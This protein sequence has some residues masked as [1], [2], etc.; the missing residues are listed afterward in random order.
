MSQPL[1][2]PPSSPARPDRPAP[3]AEEAAPGPCA[4]PPC[5]D[6]P[7]TAGPP[8]AEA[9][10]CLFEHA[11]CRVSG[12]PVRA[13]EE[14]RG[15]AAATELDRVA[16]LTAV[17]E[18][19]AGPLADGLY[20]AIG[21][22]GDKPLR[23]RLL[24]L[25][26]DV[27]NRRRPRPGDVEAAHASLGGA[28]AGRLEAYAAAASARE[29]AEARLPD[30][31]RSDL[32]HARRTLRRWAA[33]AD[34]AKGLLLSSR[35]LSAEMERYLAS[36]VAELGAKERQIERGLLRY[37]TRMAM[38]TTP[39][40]TFTALTAGR[41]AGGEES[42]SAGAEPLTFTADPRRKRSLV[43]LN[44][45]LFTVVVDDLLADRD[46]R[47]A[48]PVE[49]N[50]TLHPEDPE[51]TGSRE[52]A[53]SGA[54]RW[55]FLVS[56]D[57]L[58]VFQ[59]LAHGPV[60]DLYRQLLADGPRPLAEIEELL[61]GDSRLEAGRAEVEAFSDRLLEIGL[62][63]TRTGV[64]VQEADW[65]RPL[66]RA[67]AAVE[68]EAAARARDCL[69]RLRELCD[70]Y[71]AAAVDERRELLGTTV[72]TFRDA[73]D[74]DRRHRGLNPPFYEDAGTAA[75]LPIP[76]ARLAAAVGDLAAYVR[77]TR[78][79]AWPRRE[80]V[81]MRHFHDRHHAGR[82][83][84]LLRFYEDYHREHMKGF[85]EGRNQAVQ[86][87]AARDTLAADGEG[88]GEA[89]EAGAEPPP[90][91]DYQNPFGL[92]SVEAMKRANE[93]LIRRQRRLWRA[94]PD[95]AVLTLT[96]EDLEAATAGLP[97][98]S[99]A[100]LSTSVFCQLLPGCG[101]GGATALLMRSLLAGCG[102]Y[103]SRFLEV[104]PP[105]VR[106]DLRARN[107]SR[108]DVLLA[109]IGADGDFNANLH[110]SL[111]PWEIAYP[112]G[113]GGAAE[114][115]LR[116]PDLVVE[117]SPSEAGSLVLRHAPSG[118]RVVPL[119]LG[120]QNPMMR[121][122]LFRL[123]SFLGPPTNYYLPLPETPWEP[124]AEPDPEDRPR[125]LYR[126]RIAFGGGLFLGRRRWTVT[127]RSFPARHGAESASDHFARVD[128]WRRTHGLPR[129]VFLRIQRFTR[130]G[131]RRR[132]HLN[133]PQ[134]VD[135]ANP[136]LVDRFRRSADGLESFAMHL[137]ER[138]P[139]RDQLPAFG[140]ERFATEL[141]LQLDTRGEVGDV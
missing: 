64:P 70:D 60:V 126:P 83:V 39:F 21:G 82:P 67:L 108:Q 8:R 91:L 6:D 133:K 71:A 38:K 140:D 75:E 122:P 98:V 139:H 137:T 32:E 66:R 40:G 20:D 16:E 52:G 2:T 49:L 7:V 76:R 101:S 46:V 58:E 30:L 85:L 104:M 106:S 120:F 77:L 18:G 50:P 88:P 3:A 43:R 9:G 28:D 31:H 103:F 47:R 107:G 34:F 97:P 11:V 138:L 125:V 95:A 48:L 26:R 105:R 44:K 112:T 109:E 14:M 29:R 128:R 10:L 45:R 37:L 79:L 136:L 23:R 129:E 33:D 73:Y 17:M 41:L 89:D 93:E 78:P 53:V 100:G 61:A 27:H 56:R 42:S 12:L 92:D 123:L 80:Q 86:A 84:P 114:G 121:P 54:G 51:G 25:R 102:K 65:D 132:G 63:R 135:F 15:G 19:E 111:V 74:V 116:V 1:P 113:E 99:G 57:G 94:D 87:A 62:L 131:P 55:R 141:V 96:R 130:S 127:E 134:Y 36:P 5:T 119:D 72:R 81:A 35:V 117:R 13:A 59:R 68:G 110:P 69:G 115:E 118:K 90:D 4:D 22:C 24:R 124:G